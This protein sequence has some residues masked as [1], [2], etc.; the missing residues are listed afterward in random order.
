MTMVVLV[1][2]ALLTGC[3]QRSED[4]V[5]NG[6]MHFDKSIT[7]GAAMDH[8][9]V[10][11]EKRWEAF[12]TANTKKVV[13]FTCKQKDFGFL[14]RFKNAAAASQE[15]HTKELKPF[16]ELQEAVYTFQWT[17]QQDMRFELTFE[18][19]ERVAWK[20]GMTLKNKQE[21]GSFIEA[22]Y[23]NTDPLFGQVI[24]QLQQINT[25][26]EDAAALI[27]VNLLQ[28]LYWAAE[29]LGGKVK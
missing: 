14:E 1:G 18:G 3:T 9:H 2:A 13:Q 10:C 11:Q 24:A 21:H 16:F 5:K 4:V 23:A 7:V 12:E 26:D 29:E 19:L 15:K 25:N 28:P 27:G 22:A 8:W 20:N 6:Y 17:I